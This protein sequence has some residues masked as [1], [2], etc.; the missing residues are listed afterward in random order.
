MQSFF[1][2]S[3]IAIFSA[4]QAP[5]WQARQLTAKKWVKR[6]IP[7]ESIRKASDFARDDTGVSEDVDMI[8]RAMSLPGSSTDSRSIMGPRLFDGPSSDVPG[9]APG[10]RGIY[11]HGPTT[12]TPGTSQS[13]STHS[14][15]DPTIGELVTH[16]PEASKYNPNLDPASWYQNGL[17][18]TF[19]IDGS[20]QGV[21]TRVLAEIFDVMGDKNTW[22]LERNYKS[23]RA[24]SSLQAFDEAQFVKSQKIITSYLGVE[25]T[26]QRYNLLKDGHA[27]FHSW[28]L[29]FFQHQIMGTKSRYITPLAYQR[30]SSYKP[31]EALLIYKYL[32]KNFQDSSEA[33]IKHLQTKFGQDVRSLLKSRKEVLELGNIQ[34]A[35]NLAV[36]KGTE[37]SSSELID[38]ISAQERFLT[39]RDIPETIDEAVVKKIDLNII[40]LKVMLPQWL[41][42]KLKGSNS[43]TGFSEALMDDEYMN[44][45]RGF[46]Q[47][48]YDVS[49][50]TWTRMHTSTFSPTL[51]EIDAGITKFDVSRDF[52]KRGKEFKDAADLVRAPG[53]VGDE[54][55]LAWITIEQ[56][57]KNGDWRAKA[58]EEG[59]QSRGNYVTGTKLAHIRNLIELES[60]KAFGLHWMETFDKYD[61]PKFDQL[62]KIQ[63]TINIVKS[64]QPRLID[65]QF[66]KI[67]RQL[68]EETFGIKQQA[69]KRF[70]FHTSL[71]NK[72]KEHQEVIIK[73]IF[74]SP[75]DSQNLLP[76]IRFGSTLKLHELFPTF[77]S[78][79]KEDVDEMVKAFGALSP[80]NLN[81]LEELLGKESMEGE[82]S[83][84]PNHY[85]KQ[86]GA[87]LKFVASQLTKPL[88]KWKDDEPKSWLY[89]GMNFQRLTEFT[90]H[91]E[92][93]S[94]GHANLIGIPEEKLFDWHGS[95]EEEWMNEALAKISRGAGPYRSNPKPKKF[96]K[97]DWTKKPFKAEPPML[98]K[99]DKSNLASTFFQRSK[100]DISYKLSSFKSFSW[101]KGSNSPGKAISPEQSNTPEKS[102]SNRELSTHLLLKD[103]SGSESPI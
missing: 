5:L 26:G 14:K 48:L 76:M 80:Q 15:G 83:E 4:F 41:T 1:F 25:E 52:E 8:G 37:T 19:G 44:R 38:A 2:F 97:F 29:A 30:I 17:M 66:S 7:V 71:V 63:E 47:K 56:A 68:G 12:S 27:Q 22:S 67:R 72:W 42:P 103:D 65:A 10:D 59:D 64:L 39:R 84:G 40:K 18:S 57:K 92:I 75:K 87:R 95:L 100:T 61:H 33:A 79:K 13:S 78:A 36:E 35:L 81:E 89:Y 43:H 31:K 3:I 55:L 101:K 74:D 6:S 88:Q 73:K 53:Y 102:I 90:N 50:S 58:W 24:L 34:E 54:H 96:E 77:S 86:A 9:M 28:I 98:P 20:Y 70:E 94:A 85:I 62:A 16:H 93:N 21:Y 99:D 69:L 45:L 46:S 82:E 11:E 51:S 91:L 60:Y 49:P 32:L 23:W